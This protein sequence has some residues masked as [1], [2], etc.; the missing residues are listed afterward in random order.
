[1][2]RLSLT[3]DAIPLSTEVKKENSRR[4]CVFLY[5]GFLATSETW[6]VFESSKTYSGFPPHLWEALSVVPCAIR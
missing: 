2:P 1:M 5:V 3:R 6:M 4:T